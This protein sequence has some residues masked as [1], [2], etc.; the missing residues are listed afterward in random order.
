MASLKGSYTP[1]KNQRDKKAQWFFRDEARPLKNGNFCL[2][3]RKAKISTT[4]IYRIF[5][6]LKFELDAGTSVKL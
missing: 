5:R 4:G 2:S 1:A 6:G 3:S